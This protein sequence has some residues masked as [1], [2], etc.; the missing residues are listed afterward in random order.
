V[1]RGILGVATQCHFEAQKQRKTELPE[2]FDPNIDALD[3]NKLLNQYGKIGAFELSAGAFKFLHQT[4]RLIQSH[5]KLEGTVLCIDTNF[6]AFANFAFQDIDAEGVENFFLD[7][8]LERARTVNRVVS[9]A[10][11]QFLGRIG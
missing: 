8:A 7:R 2:C 3:A 1:R 10:G 4:Q 6:L 9:F 5:S 11:E